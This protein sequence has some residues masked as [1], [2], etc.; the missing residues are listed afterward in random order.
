MRRTY[1]LNNTDIDFD[2]DISSH[3]NNI[4]GFITE[5]NSLTIKSNS[6][7]VISDMKQF[8]T[9]DASTSNIF[10][11]LSRVDGIKSKQQPMSF[12]SDVSL[13]IQADR[14]EFAEIPP[15]LNNTVKV[16]SGFKDNFSPSRECEWGDDFRRKM[17]KKKKNRDRE[18]KFKRIHGVSGYTEFG[19]M[20][21]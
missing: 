4:T 15:N 2:R 14:I 9:V 16:V 17:R 3:D 13:K 7:S 8:G 1:Q 20:F 5:D 11:A 21:E 18:K 19:A 6:N 12:D 10:D